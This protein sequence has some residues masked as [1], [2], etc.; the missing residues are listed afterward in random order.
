MNK[1][2]IWPCAF[3]AWVALLLVPVAYE[4]V[5]WER[6]IGRDPDMSGVGELVGFLL[7]M[8]S[9]PMALLAFAVF[10]PLAIGIDYIAKGRTTRFVN[11]LIGAAL[12][13]PALV[14]SVVASGWPEHSLSDA[15]AVIRDPGRAAG[16]VAALPVAGMIVG[17]GLRH[18]GN[19]AA[20]REARPSA[21]SSP[22][23]A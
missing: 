14:V 13:A 17:L 19:G 21:S 6:G 12:C 15:M 16:F 18:R 22:A 23:G 8:L 10:A 1:H 5:Q 3:L 20:R 9:L 4:A 11:A 2:R 7:F